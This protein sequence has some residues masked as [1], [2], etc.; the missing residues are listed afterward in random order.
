MPTRTPT[1]PRADSTDTTFRAAGFSVEGPVTCLS[2]RGNEAWIGGT[3][4]RIES[5]DAEDQSLVGVDMWWRVQDNGQ[6]AG[7][8]P[9]R[10]DRTRLRFPG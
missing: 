2:I 9:D 7:D 8:A 5:P 1:G 4:A 6:G 10:I 3:V